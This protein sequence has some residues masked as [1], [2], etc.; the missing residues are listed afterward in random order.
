MILSRLWVGACRGKTAKL[1]AITGLF[2]ALGSGAARAEV[3]NYTRFVTTGKFAL[4]VEPQLIVTNGAGLGV[5]ARYTH[6]LNDLMNLSINLGNG[7]GPKQ[8]R[9]GAALTFDFFPDLDKQPG[10]GVTLQ[11][12]FLHAPLLNRASDSTTLA[13]QVDL[14]AIPYLHKALI[15]QGNEVDPFVALPTGLLFQGGLYRTKLMVV[16]GAMF[17]ITDQ[18]RTS[19]EAGIAASN[20][21]SYFSG[22]LTYYH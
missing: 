8:A 4:A 5:T 20:A 22:G 7:S 21:D 9:A 1:V 14:L 2:I 15:F 19:L 6:G 10:L 12:D 18:V 11:G 13:S 17:R 3:L 16:A